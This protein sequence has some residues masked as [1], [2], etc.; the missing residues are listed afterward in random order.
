[1]AYYNEF[2][3]DPSHK[4]NRII[5]VIVVLLSYLFMFVLFMFGGLKHIE[6]PPPEYGIELDMSGGG[7]G[8]SYSSSEVSGKTNREVTARATVRQSAKVATQKLEST[9]KVI[10]NQVKTQS[11]TDE[12]Q[13]TEP[14]PVLNQ[15]AMFK[16]KKYA[17]G[18]GGGTGDGN[19]TGS[20]YGS[21]SGSGGGF[22]SGIGSGKGDFWLN[23]RPVV[24]KAYPPG[25]SNLNGKVVVVIFRADKEGNVVYAKIGRG[26]TVDDDTVLEDCLRAAKS[27]KFKAKPDAIS[28]E[29]GTITYKFRS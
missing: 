16:K 29:Q 7:G 25:R 15:A 26:T 8:G 22:G 23:G 6:P 14:Q 24:Y 2:T 27:S 11:K 17:G 21:G 18:S 12:I 3:D 5:A 4:K 13:E 1:M 9:P 20:G 19:G 28:E 10:P